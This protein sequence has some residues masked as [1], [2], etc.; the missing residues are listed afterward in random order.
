MI[1]RKVIKI[2]NSFNVSLLKKM[3]IMNVGRNNSHESIN[4]D[5]RLLA[6]LLINIF[7]LLSVS[8]AI[9]VSLFIIV[10]VFVIYY[11]R[12]QSKTLF[13]VSLLLTCNTCLAIICSST[14]LILIQLSNIG[15]D[16]HIISL[17]WIIFWGCHIR[18]YLLFLFINS[19][20]LSYVLQAGYR[21]F[22]I[23]FHENSCL[24]S[25]ST[26]FCYIVAQWTISFIILIP[27]LF[28]GDNH[29][30]SI[31]YLPEDFYCQVPVTNIYS[32][33]YTIFAV[34][35]SPLCCMCIIYFWIII[36]VRRNTRHRRAYTLQI[37]H[38]NKRDAIIT[39][40]ICVVMT[41]LLV[42]CVP[43]II[44]FIVFIISGQLHWAFYRLSWMIV[45]ISYAFICL[46]SIYVTPQIY[47]PISTIFRYSARRKRNSEVLTTS[48]CITRTQTRTERSVLRKMSIELDLFERTISNA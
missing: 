19:I 1:K 45:S 2:A 17:K 29:T 42:L 33:I 8:F 25:F 26:F 35:V 11:S 4:F 7:T 24:R 37:R 44:F 32:M 23:V 30:T 9:I 18:G 27:I 6:K 20:Y 14:I 22:R 3:N 31:V 21:L 12:T 41:L 43:S 47:R 28:T 5:N 40:R 10:Y 39:K 34:Y 36:Y 13:N 48:T 16:H 15:G 38:Q 46:S